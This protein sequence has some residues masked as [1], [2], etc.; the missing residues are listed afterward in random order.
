MRAKTRLSTDAEPGRQRAMPLPF[1]SLTRSNPDQP[2]SLELGAEVGG[3][4]YSP[5]VARAHLL[6]SAAG[7]ASA[8]RYAIHALHAATDV[9]TWKLLRRDLRL[10][11]DT[12][13]RIMLDLVNGVL[14]RLSGR[15]RRE[16]SARRPR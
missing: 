4:Q 1:T 2:E 14:D 3:W 9:Y 8:R 12:T 5:G 15:A 13:E 10:G 6:G 11:R 16:R 7:G